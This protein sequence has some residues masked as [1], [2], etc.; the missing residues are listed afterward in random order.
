MA[1]TEELVIRL[2][3]DSK[4]AVVGLKDAE[5]NL[6]SFTKAAKQAEDAASTFKKVGL[7]VVVL[8][9]AL[10]VAQKTMSALAGPIQAAT[11]AFIEHDKVE[12]K[13]ANTLGL[14]GQFSVEALNGF[15]DFASE[16]ERTTTVAG[17]SALSLLTIAKT[18]GQTDKQA[19]LLVKTAADLS[20][21]TGDDLNTSF[22][23]LL[24]TTSGVAGALGKNGALSKAVS[25]L[26]KSQL[27]AGQAIV[28]T[29]ERLKGFSENEAKTLSGAITQ[30]EGAFG[31][32]TE[33]IGRAVVRFIDLPS[34]VAVAKNAFIGLQSVVKRVSDQLEI[35][36]NAFA[37]IDWGSLAQSILVVAGTFAAFKL[38]V[39]ALELKAAIVAI[40]GM[41][42]AI[43]AMGGLT[44]ILA[45]IKLFFT[46]GTFLA[47]GK[48]IAIASA[49][50]L[51]IAA[52]II[53]V[54]GAVDI[55]IRNLD[56]L[57]QLFEMISK[58]G[59]TVF[60]RL[61]RGINSLAVGMLAAFEA[62]LEPMAKF[63][64]TADK[65]LQFVR[66]G[67]TGLA[68]ELDVVNEKIEGFDKQ[69]GQ[70]STGIDFGFIG[71]G[72]N[73]IKNLMKDTAD[74]SGKVEDNV[75][76]LPPQIEAAAAASQKF[77]DLMKS[78]NTE[79][80]SLAQQIA[81]EGQDEIVRL[82]VALAFDLQRLDARREEIAL[83]LQRGEI[84]QS[85][86]DAAI[87]GLEQQKA[88]I[89][90]L[91]KIRI[92]PL[93]PTTIN[94]M[95]KAIGGAVDKFKDISAKV[96]SEGFTVLL[97]TS[98][99]LKNIGKA[100]GNGIKEVDLK[101][102]GGS[103]LS[104][105]GTVFGGIIAA[106]NPDN[107]NKLA[108]MLGNFLAELPDLLIKAFDSLDK[109]MTK[110][111]D[112]FPAALQRFLDALPGIV[113]KLLDK[114]PQ[115]IQG[116]I[117]GFSKF[118][119]VLPGI[120]QRIFDKLPDLIAQLVKALPGLVRQIFSAIGDIIASL[121]DAIPDILNELFE[122]FPA[123]VEAL[124]DGIFNAMD[125]IAA[126]FVDFLIGGGLE[127]I[128]ASFLRMIPR[129]VVAIVRG[130]INGLIRS[131]GRVFSGIK[132]PDSITNFPQKF[133][134]GA[135]SLGQK[136][137]NE[138][139]KLFKVLDLEQQARGLGIAQQIQDAI[140]SAT[141]RLGT[142][143]KGLIQWLVEAWQKI[144]AALTKLWTW[145]NDNIF[146]PIIQALQAVWQW[147]WEKIL[148]PIGEVIGKAW[149][150]VLSFFEKF[151]TII[152]DAWKSVM[153]FFGKI[154]EKVS[155]A[156]K[157][158]MDFFKG[159]GTHISNGFKDALDQLKNI[160]TKIWEK[161]SEGIKNGLSGV[162][163]K[164]NPQN[165]FNKMFD[166]SGAMGKTGTVEKALK[167][168]IPFLSFA[169]GGMV[170]NMVPGKAAFPGDN[171]MNDTVAAM[172]SPGEVV[173]PRSL[174]ADP[175][176]KE[177]VSGIMTGSLR[178][179]FKISAGGTTIVDTGG[180]GPNIDVTDPD[181]LKIKDA[182]KQLP[183]MGD[184]FD[185]VLE[186]VMKMFEQNSFHK[187]GYVGFATGGEVPATLKTGEF[188]MNNAATDRL[189]TGFLGALNR[190]A[191]PG[192]TQDVNIE[193]NVNVEINGVRPQDMD[194]GFIRQ[195]LM[196]TIKRELKKA[197]FAGEAIISPR[198]LTQT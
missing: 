68:D 146:Q 57:P 78:I 53:A 170:P 13:L 84:S 134:D 94:S 135:K 66:K 43:A 73:F 81:T 100:I 25:A 166:G 1:V 32:F 72:F 187:G 101:K 123:F 20:A 99:E 33:E 198:G 55:L 142:Q 145:V 37:A 165:I 158:V 139:S 86:M 104:G 130:I 164:I 181:P 11:R 52:A 117:D 129:L 156:F 153:D 128:V 161:L 119:D 169:Q 17:D 116:F 39:F 26:T 71:Q 191:N 183:N 12:K 31:S 60:G 58:V 115:L 124:I 96:A 62:M 160:G 148:Q 132:L 171:R 141:T 69:I 8:N 16:M 15:K 127:K 163:E 107:I 197:T 59:A 155:E 113:Q 93:E 49:K 162:L 50:F 126:A 152:S 2:A 174:M 4:G 40:G 7:S 77:L 23:Q 184:M 102:A 159:I 34:L 108:D 109:A 147:V 103:L 180:G 150:A 76:N 45:Q 63:S 172:L 167:I 95:I 136:L 92:E 97:P 29:A 182:A 6:Q 133:V 28:L 38:A 105:L 176:I 18:M 110:F 118:I 190:G 88:L 27:E 125:K 173:I 168:D 106:F 48:A 149:H 143:F 89:E 91:A 19:M 121:I 54:A 185:R 75:K 85:E 22:D 120:F 79:N 35:I 3:V 144:L 61:L 36:K 189:G 90:N 138:S 70:L 178:S 131:I 9:Q 192:T 14:L 137:T 177:I 46:G 74:E 179:F 114:L 195:R 47:A 175:L 196:P 10:E 41:N 83:M 111:I 21:A 82:Q 5:G 87:M 186:M 112:K 193:Q 56:R 30:M 64:D 188:V 65:A 98:E 42:A 44:G 24:K 194:E 80:L 140:D 122:G 67:M 157:P 154:H 51:G 151:G